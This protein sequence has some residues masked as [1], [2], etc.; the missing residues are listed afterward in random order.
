[1][2]SSKTFTAS[3]GGRPITLVY[4]PRI[5]YEEGGLPPDGAP[6]GLVA[7]IACMFTSLISPSFSEVKGRPNTQ[8][9]SGTNLTMTLLALG[10]S[11]SQKKIDCQGPR[12]R[13]PPSTRTTSD[14]PKRDALM[15][16]AEFPSICR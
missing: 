7:R 14:E 9:T 3:N 12:T 11:N 2:E 10:P 16:A 8:R 13:L 5:S 4:K 6:L 1:M 15:C